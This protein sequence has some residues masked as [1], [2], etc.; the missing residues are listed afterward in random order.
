MT[1]PT[2]KAKA[3]AKESTAAAPLIVL[4]YDEHN[5]PQA[6]EFPAGCRPGRQGRPPHGSQGL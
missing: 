6:A 5:K 1:K 4:G 3:S 2:A